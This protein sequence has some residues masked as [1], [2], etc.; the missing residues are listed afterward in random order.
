MK[1]LFLTDNFPPETNA[2]A[3]RVMERARYW[4][5]WG[6]EV[7][8][9]TS[10]P[11][12]PQGR[13]YPGY[14]NAWRTVE[15][16]EGIRV[17][18]V[19][20]FIAA[21]EGSV[22]RILDFLSYM[23]TAIMFGVFEQK[24]DVVAATSPQFFTGVSGWALAKVF[25]VPFVFEIADLWP[26][27]LGAVGVIDSNW[28]LWPLERLELF[29][30]HQARRV[31][32]L[33]ESFRAD[34]MRRK[35]SAEKVKTIINGVEMHAFYPTATDL[36]LVESLGLQGQFVVAYIGTL[37][38]SHGLES[39]LKA[40]QLLAGKSSVHF[41]FVGSGSELARL[42][43][44]KQELG[45]SNVTFV[46]QKPKAEIVKYWSICDMAL[47]SLRDGPIL[48]TVIPSK[49]FEAMACGKPVILA[50]PPGEASKIVLES[51]CGCVVPA[52]NP[53]ALALKLLELTHDHE[54]R[55]RYTRDSFAAAK[56][57][58]RERQA[59]EMLEAMSS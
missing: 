2:A 54:L 18:R 38:L 45:L 36:A 6:H 20:T 44:L 39:I 25:R 8:I 52:E 1:I 33:T 22:L 30:Y 46:E 26:A 23:I 7:C 11:N 47:V 31:V 49:I 21:N 29:L 12:K 58:S 17:V 10:A 32:T 3:S 56:N 27:A 40:A 59:R 50:G 37:G 57:Y 53:E 19:K 41:L 43:L 51:G 15:M 48:S 14:K 24:P 55:A 34:L 13:V 28:I 42:K 4:V 5:K 9:L 16:V 35:V